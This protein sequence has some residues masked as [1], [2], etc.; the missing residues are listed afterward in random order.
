MG[1]TSIPTL[2]ARHPISSR[3]PRRVHT[4][5]NRSSE[6]QKNA[7]EE[8]KLISE[9]QLELHISRPEL[10]AADLTDIRCA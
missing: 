3:E 10:Q 4:S 2:K 7:P 1:T 8:S 6:N 5:L 9:S